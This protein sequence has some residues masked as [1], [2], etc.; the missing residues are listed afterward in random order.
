VQCCLL[1]L[2]DGILEIVPTI[3]QTVAEE[4]AVHVQS[5]GIK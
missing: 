2:I 1:C 5:N 4:L 3:F